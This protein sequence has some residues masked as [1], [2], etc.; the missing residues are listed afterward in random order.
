MIFI[1]NQFDIIYND[2]DFEF[3]YDVKKL[4]NFIIINVFFII[5]NDNKHE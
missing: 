2:F 4:K 3:R 1:K 5:F